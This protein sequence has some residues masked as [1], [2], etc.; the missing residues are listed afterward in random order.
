MHSSE[1][2]IAEIKELETFVEVARHLP[3][4]RL[5]VIT[6]G[7][8]DT[9]VA[10][11]QVF[12]EAEADARLR[13]RLAT[14]Y[15]PVVNDLVHVPLTQGQFD[16]LVSFVYNV[17]GRDFAESTLRTKLN[18]RDYKGASL[19][20]PRWVI[21]NGKVEPGLVKRRAL[22]KSW[23]TGTPVGPAAPETKAA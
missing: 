21:S 8:G 20:F 10:L 13:E 18:Q 1:A 6:G 9:D 2:L 17:G 19:E 11:G 15:E 23:F 3:A 7:Y 14:S 22:E 4:D 16:A 12:T 5:N